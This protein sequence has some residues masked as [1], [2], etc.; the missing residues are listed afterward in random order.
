MGMYTGPT[1]QKTAG[2]SASAQSRVV[3]TY[4]LLDQ[5]HYGA[6]YD[7]AVDSGI[8]RGPHRCQD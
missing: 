1:Q 8:W 6:D 3:Q 2:S 5:A 7:S 4:G